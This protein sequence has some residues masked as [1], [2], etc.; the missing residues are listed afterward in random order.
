ML[1]PTLCVVR[2]GACTAERRRRAG[3]LTPHCLVS[4]LPLPRRRLPW[5]NWHSSQVRIEMDADPVLRDSAFNRA[6]LN[7]GGLANADD[8][9]TFV[10]RPGIAQWT[11]ARLKRTVRQVR[12]GPAA[13]HCVP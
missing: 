4:H 12:G 2:A 10:V 3:M 5:N 1:D 7:Q 13:C 11:R 6:P 8:L 9:E